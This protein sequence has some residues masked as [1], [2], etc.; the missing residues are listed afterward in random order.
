MEEQ[1]NK[2]NTGPQ[3]QPAQGEQQQAEQAP[4]EEASQQQQEQSGDAGQEAPA[5][6][7]SNDV[8]ENRAIAYLSYLG[9][10]FL[11]PMLVKKDSP[12]AQFHAKQG[13]VL[14]IA[15]F[16]GAFLMPVFGLGVLVYLAILVL[17]IMG[18][19]NVHKGEMKDLPIVGDIAKKFNF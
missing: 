1:K 7:G 14:V 6:A 2:E 3:E 12:F 19:V 4:V 8:E 15:S 13:L 10:L 16:V 5:V 17:S 11:V 9:L 18:L